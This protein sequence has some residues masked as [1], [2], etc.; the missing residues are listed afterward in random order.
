MAPYKDDAGRAYWVSTATGES[1]YESP[2]EWFETPAAEYDNKPY[3]VNKDTHETTWDEPECLAWERV[4]LERP[5]P[6]DEG[7]RTNVENV[8]DDDDD[9]LALDPNDMF[10]DED[11]S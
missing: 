9:D 3:Y 5:Q 6:K 2:C 11:A 1:T 8:E 7:P 10:T 4:E